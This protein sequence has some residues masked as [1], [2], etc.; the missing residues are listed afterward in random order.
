MVNWVDISNEDWNM[1]LNITGDP[2]SF[3]M[4]TELD[5]IVL[6]HLYILVVLE[7][8]FVYQ[9]IKKRRSEGRPIFS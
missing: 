5:L 6:A 2:E 7:I 1:S 8:A 3:W 9:I 4:D